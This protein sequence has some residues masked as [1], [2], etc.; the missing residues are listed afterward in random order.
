MEENAYAIHRL[1]H[2]HLLAQ[3]LIVRVYDSELLQHVHERILAPIL[4]PTPLPISTGAIRTR[5]SPARGFFDA[6]FAN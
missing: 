2:T 1:T 4:V 3:T 6:H 5:P